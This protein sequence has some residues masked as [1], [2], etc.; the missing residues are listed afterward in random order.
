MRVP[1]AIILACCAGLLGYAYFLEY[2]MFLTPCPLCMVQRAVFFAMGVIALIGLAQGPRGWGR[3]VYAGLTTV[4]GGLGV[5]VS[6]RHLW[7]QSLPADQVPECGPGLA[8]MLENFPLAQTW[9][10]ILSGSGSCAEM[11]WQF[12]GL[13]MPA[14]TLLWYLGLALFMLGAAIRFKTP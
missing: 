13:S 1:F 8:Y 7:L 12:L 11:T 3:W 10:A 5:A 4:F 9:N 2:R 6:A 14:W